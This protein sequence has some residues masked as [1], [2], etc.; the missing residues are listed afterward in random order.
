MSN[1]NQVEEVAATT[2]TTTIERRS[3][4]Q[5]VI[6][7]VKCISVEPIYCLYVFT[8]S[9]L[10]TAMTNFENEKVSFQIFPKQTATPS[11]YEFILCLMNFI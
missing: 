10:N 4:I 3:F 7:C 2:A 6:Y 5:N 11:S 8:A 9:L 1:N